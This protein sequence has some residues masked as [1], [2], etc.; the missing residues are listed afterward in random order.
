MKIHDAFKCTDKLS[1]A[2]YVLFYDNNSEKY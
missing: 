1:T 2:I